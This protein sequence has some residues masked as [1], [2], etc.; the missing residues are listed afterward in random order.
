MELS[1]ALVAGAGQLATTSLIG[2]APGIA[3]FGAGLLVGALIVALATR[4]QRP[5]QRDGHVATEPEAQPAIG[6]TIAADPVPAGHVPALGA[7]AARQP[8]DKAPLNP[9]TQA[10]D[11]ERERPAAC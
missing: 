6:A 1:P 2:R 9:G 10:P 8:G 5:I 11:R 4:L 3:M 7:T